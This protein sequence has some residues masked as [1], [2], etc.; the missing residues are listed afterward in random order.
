MKPQVLNMKPNRLILATW[1]PLAQVVGSCPD[2]YF[3]RAPSCRNE[4]FKC[5]MF[6]TSGAGWNLELVMHQAT[7]WN[8]P[9]AV[10]ITNTW[11]D[12]VAMPVAHQSLFYWWEPDA[13]FL[14][15]APVEVIFPPHDS[16]GHANGD[17]KTAKRT[18]KLSKGVSKDLSSLSPR[19][20]NFLVN[21]EISAT[22]IQAI[23][24]DQKNTGILSGARLCCLLFDLMLAE[25]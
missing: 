25:S 8:M 23:L 9:I 18:I 5:V 24:M 20:E 4:T 22:M 11:A 16:I 2:E 3:W 12:F 1:P 15:M 7:A 21:M 6:F 17:F 14:E 10:A 19:V 13:T